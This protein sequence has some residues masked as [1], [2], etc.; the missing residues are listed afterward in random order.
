MS[1]LC[2]SLLCVPDDQ[3]V[4]L[5]ARMRKEKKRKEKTRKEK[6]R[7]DKRREEKSRKETTAPFDIISISQVVYQAAQVSQNE[8]CL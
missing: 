4:H 2:V 6:K 3:L 1:L 5:K 7:Q 8:T